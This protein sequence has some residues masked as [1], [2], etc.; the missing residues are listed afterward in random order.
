MSKFQPGAQVIHEPSGEISIVVAPPAHYQWEREKP[1]VQASWT[2]VRKSNGE[3]VQTPTSDLRPYM[4]HGADET[5]RKLRGST[6]CQHCGADYPH[7]HDRK[8]FPH[9]KGTP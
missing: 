1:G 7:I 3:V 5:R 8:G 4:G 9:P 6:R 2:F